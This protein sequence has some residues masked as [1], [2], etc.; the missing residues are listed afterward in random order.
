[1]AISLLVSPPATSRRTSASRS[2]RP[3][4]KADLLSPSASRASSCA[5]IWSNKRAAASKDVVAP[6][7]SPAV[8]NAW[9][10]SV[11]AVASSYGTPSA[12]QDS[13]ACS[14]DHGRG[15]SLHRPASA[16]RESIAR[17]HEAKLFRTWRPSSRA[18]PGHGARRRGPW[19]LP[20]S[21][22]HGQQARSTEGIR[23][24]GHAARDDRH[25]LVDATLGQAEEREP[26]A[27][28]ATDLL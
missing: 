3:A 19:L 4:G 16:G 1:M 25:G 12:R 26:T 5:P 21:G 28:R 7:S 18:R 23:L 20:R 17:W 10:R 8:R 9:P 11:R 15:S 2:V 14:Q 6:C 22:Q 24:L 13:T 27:G